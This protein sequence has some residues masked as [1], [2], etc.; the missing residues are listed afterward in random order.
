MP[1]PSWMQARPRFRPVPLPVHD[2]PA[3]A[4]GWRILD[5]EDSYSCVWPP[6]CAPDPAAVEYLRSFF[7]EVILMFRRQRWMPPNSN[8]VV[9]VGHWCAGRYFWNPRNP[10]IPFLC[11]MP[12]DADFIAPNYIDYVAEDPDLGTEGGPGP[13]EP[14]DMKLAARMRRAYSEAED[15]HTLAAKRRARKEARE[16]AIRKARAE[17]R[18]QWDEMQRWIDRKLD[19]RPPTARDWAEYR[20][21]NLARARGEGDKKAFVYVQG[22]SL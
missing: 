13:Y 18:R 8:E 10:P 17:R 20:A 7:P 12:A 19:G 4:P 3:N 2:S 14:F 5:D 22:A 16:T 1:L 15:E 6:D 11:E 21:K 9:V